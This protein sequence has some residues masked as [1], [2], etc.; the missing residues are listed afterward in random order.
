MKF[1][2]KLHVILWA[3]SLIF[4]VDAIKAAGG[5]PTNKMELI[6]EVHQV[7][8]Q[9]RKNAQPVWEAACLWKD[10]SL[11]SCM[12]RPFACHSLANLKAKFTLQDYYKTINQMK[13]YINKQVGETLHMIDEDKGDFKQLAIKVSLDLQGLA[14]GCTNMKNEIN[15]KITPMKSFY[16]Q[17]NN[18]KRCW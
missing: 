5:P 4:F 1:Y 7:A 6:A 2:L 13:L 12:L 18:N 17:L 11:Y 9:C 16:L 14:G 8:S 15:S 3:I 10:T